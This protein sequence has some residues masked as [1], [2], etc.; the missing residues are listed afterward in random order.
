MFSMVAMLMT[1]C[2]QSPDQELKL[3]DLEYF[4]RQ[5]VNVLV[6]SNDF[7]G[8]FND[9]KNSGIELIHHGV[10]TAQGGAVRLSNTPEQWDLVPASPVRKVDKENGSIEVGLRYEDYDFDSRVVVT[11]KGKAVEIAVYLDKPVPEELE[12]DAGFNLEFLPSQYWNK[13][14]VMDGRYNRFPSWQS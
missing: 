5:G 8:G 4:E 11:A 1:A 14:Y 7:S 9:E 10:R 2:S 3:N 6:Y 12:G 13:A